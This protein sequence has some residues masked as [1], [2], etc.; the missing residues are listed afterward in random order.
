MGTGARCTALYVDVARLSVEN[1]GV[2]T[3]SGPSSATGASPAN[4]SSNRARMFGT[5]GIR[6][7]ANVHPMT[8]EVA[9]KVGMAVGRHF[10]GHG[11]VVVGKDTRRSGY[12]FE[13]ALASGLCAMGVDVMLVGPLPTPGIAYIVQSMRADAGVV[14]SASHNPHQD[15][16]VKIFGSDGYKLPDSV[17]NELEGLIASGALSEQLADAAAIGKAVRIDDATGRYVTHVKHAFP[18]DLT[19]DGLKV[20]VDCAHGAAYKVAPAVFDELGADVTAIGVEPD[21][22]NINADCGALHP[23]RVAAAVVER[24]ADVGIALDGDA[25]RLVL[26]DGEGNVIDGD[27]ALAIC[28]RSLHAESALRG[29]KVAATIMSN[30]G[31]ERSLEAIGVELVRTQVGDRYV[32]E[33]MREQGLNL[34]GEQS[35]HLLF[36]DH[37]T[38]GD[39]VIAALQVLR[40][41][42]R[43]GQSLA[44]LA[45]VFEP[46]PQ[47]SKSFAVAQKIPFEQLTET[48]ALLSAVR[49]KLSG[50]G[51]VV[52]RYSGTES[53]LRV[54]VEGED[55]A[56]I[57]Q[58]VAQIA[59]TAI[60]E[61]KAH[62]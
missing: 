21:G 1:E 53:K 39:G 23:E 58:H 33:A 52:V 5:D 19:L 41:M 57:E 54:M 51:R 61:I 30:L 43:S 18:L 42:R 32:V 25:D 56:T 34:G 38:T 13:T 9:L 11:R 60:A 31:L 59:E 29:G 4:A 7:V 8:S 26:A 3:G 37:G 10:A 35:G 36:L 2:M 15:N 50:K 6:G 12:M 40:I 17:E 14:I 44:D 22:E 48:S 20:V 16:G 55:V 28:A 49:E 24:G 27:A 62:S 46:V 47:C 45:K